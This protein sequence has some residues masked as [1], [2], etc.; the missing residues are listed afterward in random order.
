MLPI[1]KKNLI[2]KDLGLIY[3]FLILGIPDIELE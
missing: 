2:F 3:F 1:L